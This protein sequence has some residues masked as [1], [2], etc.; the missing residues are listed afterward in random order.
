MAA[1][2]HIR[3]SWGNLLADRLTGVIVAREPHDARLSDD[4]EDCSGY[5]DVSRF[6]PVVFAM[7]AACS[8]FDILE[9]GYWTPAGRYEEPLTMQRDGEGD[10][11]DWVPLRFLPAPSAARLAAYSGPVNLMDEQPPTCARC[12]C[13]VDVEHRATVEVD[14]DGPIYLGTC[15]G[16]GLVGLF[17]DEPADW[18]ARI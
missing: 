10:F 12:G 15:C 4:E 16:C 3:G 13:R 2:V 14:D 18:D 17:Q 9:C 11:L 8:H 7:Q 1:L 5:P 6:D